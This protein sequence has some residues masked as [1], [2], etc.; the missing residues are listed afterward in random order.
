MP[1]PYRLNEGEQRLAK[2]IA[3]CRETNNQALAKR[4]KIVD[5]KYGSGSSLDNLIN[6]YGAEIAVCR[7]LNKCPDMSTHVTDAGHY[8]LVGFGGTIDVKWRKYPKS[9]LMVQQWKNKEGKRCDIYI[10]VTGEMP[11]YVVVGY[12][13]AEHI[14]RDDRIATRIQ[15][16][17][18]GVAPYE[19][20]QC[21]LHPF[22]Q[23]HVDEAW[24]AHA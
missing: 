15:N 7:L 6:A 18:G 10:L 23:R 9:S 5:R 12:A 21:A 20:E 14:F 16:P 4:G 11:S 19:I 2:F 1:V 17:V 13:Y 8:D 3:T 24:R 22:L